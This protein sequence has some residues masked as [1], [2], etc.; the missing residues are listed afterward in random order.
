[1]LDFA[2]I[3]GMAPGCQMHC[4]MAPNTDAGCIAAFKQ[5]VA[6]GMD[7]ISFS[8][9]GPEDQWTSATVSSLRHHLPE[10]RR[11]RYR[12]HLRGRRQRLHG[13]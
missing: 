3:G 5:A 7:V 12:D 11:G 13:R 1:M 6:D 8:W 2:V 10:C 9:G 4:Y